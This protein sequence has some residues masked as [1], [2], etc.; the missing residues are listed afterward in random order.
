MTKKQ[1]DEIDLTMAGKIILGL[2][3]IG[4]YVPRPFESKSRYFRRVV[5]GKGEHVSIRLAYQVM[6]RLHERGWV[7]IVK[8]KNKIVSCSLTEKGKL[9]ALFLKAKIS[10]V[11]SGPWDRRWRVIIFDI[12]ESAREQRDRFRKLLKINGFRL[13]QD[14]VF[15]SPFPLNR[16]AIIYLNKT[17]LTDYIRIM[18]VDELDNEKDLIKKFSLKRA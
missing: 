6:K 15:I 16:D 5:L 2:L 9:E 10:K 13:L 7:K 8:E 3:F 4:H 14:S 1:K 18:R 17:K 12:P 11:K